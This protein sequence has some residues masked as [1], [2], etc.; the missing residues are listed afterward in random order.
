MKHFL[1]TALF[2]M[3]IASAIPQFVSATSLA[4]T[5]QSAPLEGVL[6]GLI[7]DT[8][9]SF[10]SAPEVAGKYVTFWIARVGNEVIIRPTPGI[11]FPRKHGFWRVD[12]YDAVNS[13]DKE[14]WEEVLTT[15]RDDEK[16]ARGVQEKD[17]GFSEGTRELLYIGPDFLSYYEHWLSGVG[18][19]QYDYPKVARA[20]SPMHNLPLRQVLGTGGLAAFRRASVRRNPGHTGKLPRW[21]EVCESCH[22]DENDWGIRHE[23]GRWAAFAAFR[24]GP[25]SSSSQGSD[26]VPLPSVLPSTLVGGGGPPVISFNHLAKQAGDVLLNRL[27]Q[28]QIP[29]PVMDAVLSPN[30]DLLV[31]MTEDVVGVFGVASG[32]LR[33]LNFVTVPRRSKIVMEQW[34]TG[35]NVLNWDSILKAKPHW[36]APPTKD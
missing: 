30:R 7:Y 10:D 31:V 17:E 32:N 14:I 13:D 16:T 29:S 23:R 19:W 22:G 28:S 21:D 34:A 35:K 2:M 24:G 36:T 18:R 1:T 3:I 8:P 11:L 20:E 26:D 15:H 9:E 27:P 4:P 5:P 12:S 25:S 6:L 33:L